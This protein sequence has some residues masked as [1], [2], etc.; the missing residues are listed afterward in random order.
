MNFNPGDFV[1]LRL[2]DRELECTILE[3]HDAGIVLVKLDSGYN[4]G[5]PREHIL[6][7][8]LIRKFEGK[9]NRIEEIRNKKG[10]PTIGLIVTGG[11]IASKLDAR[12]GGVAPLKTEEDFRKVYPELFK[13]ANVKIE[14]PFSMLSENMT[15]DEWIS[16]AEC[17]KKMLDDNEIEGVIVSHGTDTLHYTSAALSFFLGKLNKPVVLTYSQRSIDRASS[18]ADLNLR[19]SA[20]FALSD[21]AEVVIVGHAG[22]NDDFCYALSGAKTRKMHSSRRDAFKS[23]NTSAIAKIFTD[24]IEFLSSFNARSKNKNELDAIFSDKIVLFH[25]Y[26]GQK[27]DILEYYSLKGIKGI[28]IAGTGMGHVPTIGKNSWIPVIKKLTKAGFFVCMT[29]QT[30]Y[31]R[32]DGHVYSTGR[33]LLEAGVVFLEDM[34]PETAFVK[35]GWVLGHRSW[36]TPEKIKEKMLENFAGEFSKIL[37]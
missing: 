29:T 27:P 4:I 10:L 6:D 15:S 7:S 22:M 5:V 24:R 17:V 14:I 28:V 21:C 32:V 31:G 35:L 9:V 11:T 16:L 36:K 37:V 33:D 2:S 23:I 19:C 20:K 13:I 18:D 12:T 3:S 34:L 8:I 26:P 25:Y 30:F 1:K